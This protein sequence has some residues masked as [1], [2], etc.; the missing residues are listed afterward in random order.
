MKRLL[1]PFSLASLLLIPAAL[2]QEAA[3]DPGLTIR[4]S[5]Q[6]V[7]LDVTVRDS[8]GRV[9]KNLKPA[10]LQIFEDGVKQDIRSFKFIQAQAEGKGKNAA[11]PLT[12]T[13]NAGTPA[14]PLRA[15]NL[16]CIVFANLDA[17]TK[18]YAVNAVRDF[19]KSQIQPDTWIAVF[20]LESQLT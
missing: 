19:L 20:N 7:L 11:G 16:I 14:N 12:A 15:V 3:S 1:G 5:V 10:D 2:A 4:Q 9:V 6:E 17:F 13:A 8:R 18:Q